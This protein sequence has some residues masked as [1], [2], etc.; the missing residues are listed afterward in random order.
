MA[1]C[2]RGGVAGAGVFGAVHAAKYAASDKAVLAA[3]YDIDAGRA[4]ALA[5]RYNAVPFTNYDGFLNAVE[6]LTVAAPA[7]AHFD[8]AA[9]ALVAG[10]HVLVEKP[11][12]LTLDQADRL[13]HLARANGLALQ[14]GHQERFVFASF[15]VFAREDRPKAIE[16]RRCGPETGRGEDVSVVFDLMIHDLD[17]V[18]RLIAAE[19][20]AVEAQSIKGA[21]ALAHEVEARLVFD[22]GLVASFL[23][24]R[25][26]PEGERLMRL[27]YEDG[28]IE[29]D[30]MARRVANT[31][32]TP[33][34][35][36]FTDA[37]P[38]VS[39]TDPLGYGVERFFEAVLTGSPPPVTGPQARAALEWALL[40]DAAA[41]ANEEA[42]QKQTVSA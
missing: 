30:F 35:G 7:S 37:S 29:I 23:A 33:L 22:N 11:I 34:G 32:S 18:R 15:G 38:P 14:A 4:E 13:N 36:D 10:R 2:I 3:V 5:R 25:R 12:A 41:R 40:I 31:T 16:C 28:T 1:H 42:V 26:A 24:S 21:A 9:A 6:A 17:L 19:P 20:G 8:L 27:I 39:V